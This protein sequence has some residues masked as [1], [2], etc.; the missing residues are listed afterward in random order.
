MMAAAVG[1]M[2][3]TLRVPAMDTVVPSSV[4][5]LSPMPEPERNLDSLLI[6]PPGVETPPPTPTQLPAVVQIP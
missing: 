6:V 4:M 2:L 1:V 3:L 5:M